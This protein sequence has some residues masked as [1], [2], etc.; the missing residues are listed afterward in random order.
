MPGWPHRPLRLVALALLCAASLWAQDASTG[1]I[2]G[3]VEDQSGGRIVGAQVVA[4]NEANSLDR[5]TLSDGEGSFAA[6]LLPPA[7]TPS[8]WRPR[9]CKLSSN[10]PFEWKSAR[11]PRSRFS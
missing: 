5:R 11:P 8:V 7:T 9:A 10:T 6:Q 4:T 3:T 1:A 2:R